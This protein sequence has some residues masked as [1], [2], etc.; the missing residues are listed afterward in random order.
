MDKLRDVIHDA[1]E[2]DK[3]LLNHIS[4]EIWKNPELC[5]EEKHSHKVLTDVLAK[6]GFAVQRGY[7]MPTAFRAEFQSP[8]EGSTD[9][10][11]VVCIICEYDA[12]PEIGHACGHNLI[13]EAGIGAALAVKAALTSGLFPGKLVVLG[14]PAEE[15]GG[16]KQ[17]L[18]EAGAFKD[19]DFAMMVH[20]CPADM[21]YP[22]VL[23]IVRV[24]VQYTG[25]EA[26]A[27]LAPWEGLNALDA[28]VACY[29]NISL[30]RQQMKPDWRIHGVIN[31]GGTKPNIIPADTQL[32]FYIRAPNQKDLETL[33]TSAIRCFEAAAHATNTEMKYGVKDHN[34]DS[35][36]F[37]KPMQDVYKKHAE[38]FGI[39]FADGAST[40]FTGSTD[41]GNVSWV[42]PSI[43][44][45]YKINSDG[46][47]HTRAF[48]EASGSPEAQKPTLIAAESMAL[49]AM[50]LFSDKK[51]QERVKLEFHKQKSTEFW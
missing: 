47:N 41:M 42:V 20:P 28:A 40:A 31:K 12:L 21:M 36:L 33:K 50:E 29:N 14:T 46:G 24:E 48:A 8:H 23:A 45:V 4:Q 37:V 25:K 44:P 38:T 2:K 51:L 34:Y 17:V 27:A 18:I 1:I 16:G 15:G 22:I 19:I 26:H 30:M 32:E 6:A 3:N 5:F 39:T 13:A 35:F 43:H 9:N 7:H 49:T 10:A 11:P